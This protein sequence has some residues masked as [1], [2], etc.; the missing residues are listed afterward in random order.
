MQHS[1]NPNELNEFENYRDLL[2]ICFRTHHIR[3]CIVHEHVDL[4]I[5]HVINL[6]TLWLL[7][8]SVS[9][10]RV[11]VVD[12]ARI[13]NSSMLGINSKLEI[14]RSPFA[15]YSNLSLNSGKMSTPRT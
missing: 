12:Q 6:V 9:Q 13:Q 14:T 15:L 4:T 7:M 1:R 5:V 3:L 2:C 10:V 11:M 8:R